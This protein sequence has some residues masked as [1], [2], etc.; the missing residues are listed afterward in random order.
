MLGA[1]AMPIIDHIAFDVAN[2]GRSIA[3]YEIALA[4]L[5]IR[6]VKRFQGQGGQEV[7]CFGRGE[8]EF[9]IAAQKPPAAPLHV[10]FVATLRTEVDAF[11]A[12][13]LAAGGKDN[14]PPGLRKYHPSYYAAYVLDLDGNNVEAVCHLNR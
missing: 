12:A 7:A 6:L 14:G 13:A 10:A 4:P 8:P 2:L 5:G 11:H 3:F 9:C 1:Q